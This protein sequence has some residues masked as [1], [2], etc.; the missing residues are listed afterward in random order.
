MLIALLLSCGVAFAGGKGVPTPIPD[1]PKTECVQ[2]EKKLVT[3]GKGSSPSFLQDGVD[4][5]Y[6][7]KAQCYLNQAFASGCLEKKF[8]AKKF[9]T[10]ERDELPALAR[11]E[12]QKAWHIY[13]KGAPYALDLRWYSSRKSVIGYTYFDRDNV[14]GAGSETRMWTNSRM[15]LSEKSYGAHQAHELSH[16]RRAGAFGHWSQHYGSVPYNMGDAAE[17][18]IEEQF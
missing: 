15:G 16:Q 2:P 18:C 17:E 5:A 1:E 14:R 9:S 6:A 12:A 8:L 3:I 10:L 13:A 11:N 7:E 4:Q